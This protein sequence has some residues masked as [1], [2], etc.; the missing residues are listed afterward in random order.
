MDL[1]AK[2]MEW[3]RGEWYLGAKV[4]RLNPGSGATKAF[5]AATGKLVWSRPQSTPGTGGVLSTGGGLVF[6][7]DPEGLFTAVRDDT[8]G[9]LCQ[10]NVGTGHTEKRT[11]STSGRPTHV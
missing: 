1:Q 9:A 3:K 4:I 2:K 10:Y 5:D 7:G 8:G 6:F 11:D